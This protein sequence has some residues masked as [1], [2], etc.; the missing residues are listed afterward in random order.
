[1][2][3][4][5]SSAPLGPLPLSSSHP[6]IHQYRGIGYLWPCNAF[7]T[8][9]CIEYTHSND[10]LCKNIMIINN[11]LSLTKKYKLTKSRKQKKLCWLMKFRLRLH[12]DLQRNPHPPGSISS[13]SSQ[14]PII[15]KLDHL[16]WKE[17]FH[18]R[19]YSHGYLFYP[20]SLNGFI[21]LLLAD[22]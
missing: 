16:N 15:I 11:C 8:L 20:A 4:H 14:H 2:W 6:Y 21:F 12:C 1:M 7:A 3:N 5:G 13:T 19:N 9:F 22:W 17:D 18:H 10:F